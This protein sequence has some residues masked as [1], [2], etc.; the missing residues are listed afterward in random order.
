MRPKGKKQVNHEDHKH[1][2]TNIEISRDQR[3]Q[4][5]SKKIE[6][7]PSLEYFLQN[8]SIYLFYKD[9][10]LWINENLIKDDL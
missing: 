7:L 1:S 3:V 5:F 6:A 10:R 4:I 8:Y 2:K 9:F